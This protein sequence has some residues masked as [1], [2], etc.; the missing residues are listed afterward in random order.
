MGIDHGIDRM[1][2]SWEIA[3]SLFALGLVVR[4][5]VLLVVCQS[6]EREFRL[7]GG[8]HSECAAVGA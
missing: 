5:K 1:I 4:G 7:S 3:V 6:R 8:G 2:L